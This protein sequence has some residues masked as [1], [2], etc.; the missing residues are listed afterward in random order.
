[1][2]TTHCIIKIVH[3]PKEIM[4]QQKTYTVHTNG[5]ECDF[6]P[7]TWICIVFVCVLRVKVFETFSALPK[8]L[9][10]RR[11]LASLIGFPPHTVGEVYKNFNGSNTSIA[12]KS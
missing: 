4:Q 9:N 3:F 11:T 7:S 12:N 8:I 1:M 6:L 10:T 5:K 2:H